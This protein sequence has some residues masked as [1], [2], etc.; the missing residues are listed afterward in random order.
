[1]AL[2]DL[3]LRLRGVLGNAVVWAG[4]W[5]AAALAI[6][7]AVMLLGLFPEATWGDALFLAFQFGVV[8]GVTGGAVAGLMSFVYRG[9]TLADLSWVRIGIGGAVATAVFV[10]LFLQTMN[11][12][13]GDGLVEWSLVLDDAIWTSVFGGSAAG[14]SVWM[15][16]RSE[17]SLEPPAHARAL[18]PSPEGERAPDPVP[19][20]GRASS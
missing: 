6:A 8:G 9:R 2:D 10:P 20:D 13:S 5:F 12:L 18:D 7:A 1:M 17:R 3:L 15:A 11:L 19:R 4:S 16:R 14:G